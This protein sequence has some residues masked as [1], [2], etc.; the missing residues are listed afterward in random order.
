M[1]TIAGILF[2][3][4]LTVGLV[5]GET[6]M[7]TQEGQITAVNVDNGTVTIQSTTEDESG[8]KEVSF[9]VNDRTEIIKDGQTI[10]LEEMEPGDRV[11]VQYEE[12]EGTR[13]ALSIGI[14]RDRA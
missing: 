10:G 2:L 14:L 1:R 5:A 13:V 6:A 4:F 12:A 11:A 3:L 8:E 9:T 7:S